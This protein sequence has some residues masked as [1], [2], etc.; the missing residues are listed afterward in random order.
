MPKVVDHEQRRDEVA[1]AVIRLSAA[2][3][4]PDRLCATRSG[5]GLVDGMLFHYFANKRELL[6]SALRLV[7]ACRPPDQGGR[8]R[9]RGR[10]LEVLATALTFDDDDTP[11]VAGLLG[12][13]PADP[14]LIEEQ[15][16]YLQNTIRLLEPIIVRG[17][18]EGPTAPT[19][20]RRSLPACSSPSAT[21]SAC[22]RC[23][24]PGL[25]H[26]DQARHMRRFMELIAPAPR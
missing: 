7:V 3:D 14:D 15:C 9:T 23:S 4:E 12:R 1:L 16:L 22:S 18:R 17:Q 2:G 13:G 19:S 11:G 25:G 26:G 20:N 21:A 10:T 6:V 5:V 24:T 8:V